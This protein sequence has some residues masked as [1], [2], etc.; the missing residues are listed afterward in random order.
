MDLP[1]QIRDAIV[2]HARTAAPAEACGLLAVDPAGRW[3]MVY[4][5]TNVEASPARFTVDPIEHFRALQH[6]ERS[7]WGIG[8]VYHSHPAGDA[9]PSPADVAGALDPEWLYVIAG[10]VPNPA[11]RGF[12]IRNGEVSEVAR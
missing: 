5:L 6:A 10:P 9:Y 3:R 8:G 2:A 11:V 12:R 1:D 7:G 4:C